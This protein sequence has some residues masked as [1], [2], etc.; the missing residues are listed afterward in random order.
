MCSYSRYLIF[1]HTGKKKHLLRILHAEYKNL[2]EGIRPVPFEPDEQCHIDHIYVDGGIAF[3]V[4]GAGRKG[5]G[6]WRQ[7]KSRHDIFSNNLPGLSVC[8]M[9]G[10]FGYGKSILTVKL[11][12]DWCTR[13]S[14]S[15]LKDVEIVLLFQMRKVHSPASITEAMK[16]Y[17][18]PENCSLSEEDLDTIVSTAKS[19]VVILDGLDEYPHFRTDK[20]S[21]IMQLISRENFKNVTKVLVTS[22]FAETR[23]IDSK[24]MRLTGF[25]NSAWIDYT[26]K[27]YKDKPQVTKGMIAY[28][29]EN[30][31]LCESL[32]SSIVLFNICTYFLC[33]TNFALLPAYYRNFEKCNYEFSK[34]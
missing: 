27:C 3:L 34:S 14:D 17:L 16:Q 24:R 10:E 11:V 5:H 29:E 4:P 9:D 7:L 6:A 32:S 13:E 20:D 28:L 8:I 2:Y 15:P 19:C 1:R 30:P 22:R 31:E 33:Q 18:L 26:S 21:E 25:D 23:L 12:H